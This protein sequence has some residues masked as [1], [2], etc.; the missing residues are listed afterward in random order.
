MSSYGKM[1]CEMLGAGIEK[2]RVKFLKDRDD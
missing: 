2:A 1:G